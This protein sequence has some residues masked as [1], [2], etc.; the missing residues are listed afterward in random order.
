M[1]EGLAP[2]P[3][4]LIAAEVALATGNDAGDRAAVE[5]LGNIAAMESAVALASTALRPGR[6]ACGSSHAHGAVRDAWGRRAAPFRAELDRRPRPGLTGFRHLDAPDSDERSAGLAEWLRV[7]A[8]ATRRACTDA[9]RYADQIDAMTARWRTRLGRVRADSAVELLLRV[10]PGA[11]VVSVESAS[12]LI[13]RS[14]ARTTDAVKALAGAGILRQ[15]NVGRRRYRVFE[16]TDVLDL[17][18]GL[19][20]ALATPSH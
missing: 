12:V 15:R 19:E 16:A 4:R 1:I 10:L 18:I 14:K 6:P 17:F 8:T 11:P 3:R 20:R 2:A 5:V 7:F 9:E 13:G